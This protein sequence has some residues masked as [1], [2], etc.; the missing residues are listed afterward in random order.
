MFV[1][2]FAALLAL[3]APL[4]RLPYFWDEA[5]YYVPA[6]RDLLLTGSPIPH[7]TVSN[8]HPPL[9]MAYLALWWKLAGFAPIVTR[10]AMLMAAAFTLLGLFRL[11]KTVANTEVAV[12][13]IILTA[14]YPVFFAQS[15]LVH[16][17][18]AAAGLTFWGVHAYVKG[19]GWEMALW[20]S[21]ATL[22]KET[23]ILAP[24]ALFVWDVLSPPVLVKGSDRSRGRKTR[25][26]I[27]LLFPLLLLAGWYGF[28][29][30]E[31][32]FVFGNPEFFRYNVK[33]TLNPLRILLALLVR[34][35]QI[36]GYFHLLMLTAAALFAMWLPPLP[37][38]GSE[39]PL[40]SRPISAMCPST[41]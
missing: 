22:T 34:L 28:H 36:A 19:G 31:T 21:L 17:D 12:T 35:W 41:S 40:L 38:P 4:L 1:L 16:L 18:L 6:A 15:S 2:S 7:S 20:F 27:L 39:V 37:G 14:V 33:A 23:A 26:S 24:L 29:Y 5:G 11:A 3:H 13:T 9:L 30:R 25:N 8:A 10:T 32:G